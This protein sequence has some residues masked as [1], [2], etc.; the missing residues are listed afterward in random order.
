[1]A[2]L[3]CRGLLFDGKVEFRLNARDKT[4]IGIVGE[5]MVF[6]E[7]RKAASNASSSLHEA[8]VLPNLYVLKNQQ[9]K[10]LDGSFWCQ[11]DCVVFTR[12]CAFVVEVK[13]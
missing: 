9:A 4:S 3:A 11:I 10:D 13:R 5:F 2:E 8:Y 7:I 1:M 6:E 12:Q